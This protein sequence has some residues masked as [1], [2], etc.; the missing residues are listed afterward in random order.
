VPNS[1]D[2][3]FV[4]ECECSDNSNKAIE[5]RSYSNSEHAFAPVQC[6]QRGNK[7]IAKINLVV[8]ISCAGN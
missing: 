1:S 4:G 2:Y 7:R 6:I 3:F 5:E 8:E